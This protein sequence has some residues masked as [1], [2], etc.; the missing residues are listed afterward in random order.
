MKLIGGGI[1][2]HDRLKSNFLTTTNSNDKNVKS[3]NDR[4]KIWHVKIDH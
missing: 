4:Y 3:Y 1:G 2:R